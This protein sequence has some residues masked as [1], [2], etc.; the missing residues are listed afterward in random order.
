DSFVTI[1]NN[2]PLGDVD[3]TGFWS[4]N[5]DLKF[6]DMLTVSVYGR[7]LGDERY[8]RAVLIP[9]LVSFGQWNEPRN[10]GITVTYDF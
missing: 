8:Y 4:A 7:N 1:F 3:A 6:R 10:Y 9:P 2:D 5:M